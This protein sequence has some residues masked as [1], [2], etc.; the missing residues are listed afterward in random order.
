MNV[1]VIV[2]TFRRARLLK[3]SL[4]AILR[5]NY[6]DFEIIL[7]DQTP[8]ESTRKVVEESFRNEPRLLYFHSERIGTAAGWNLGLSH[9]TGELILVTDDDVIVPDHW[10]SAHVQCH[11]R[12]RNEGINP[13]VVGGPSIGLWEA[14][15]PVWWPDDFLY[16]LSEFGMEADRTEFIG[17]ELPLGASYSCSRDLLEKI[18][19]FDERLGPKANRPSFLTVSGCDSEVALK[20]HRKGY[21]VYFC[22][23]AWVQHVMVSSRLNSAYYVIR[24]FREGATQ[25]LVERLV[26]N[27]SPSQNTNVFLINAARFVRSLLKILI[28]CPLAGESPA[29]KRAAKELGYLSMAAGRIWGLVLFLLFLNQPRRRDGLLEGKCIGCSDRESLT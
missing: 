24:L 18:G 7:I 29:S 5:N 11:L 10:I 9:A 28:G 4:A 16:V 17:G 12:L 23:E 15:K 6:R 8:D 21:P 26:P 22:R 19:G 3:Q 1:S 14:P 13:G 2:S 20:L 25:T 27:G